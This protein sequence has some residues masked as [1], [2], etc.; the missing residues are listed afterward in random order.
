MLDDNASQNEPSAAIADQLV[1]HT[2]AMIAHQGLDKLS[3]RT[4]AARSGCS[5]AYIFQKFGN[6]EGLMLAALDRAI[7]IEEASHADLLEQLSPLPVGQTTL[8]DFLCYYV[9]TRATA[10]V[11]RFMLSWVTTTAP[12]HIASLLGTWHAMRRDFW[13]AASL[14]CGLQPDMPAILADYALMEESYA[15]A[16][17]GSLRYD[18]LLKETIRAL[19]GISPSANKR[20]EVSIA[21]TLNVVPPPLGPGTPDANGSIRDRLL[22]HAREE[23]LQ[24]GIGAVNQRSTARNAGASNSAIAYYFGSMDA[25]VDEAIWRAMLSDIPPELDPNRTIEGRRLSVQQ[26]LTALNRHLQGADDGEPAG[27]YCTYARLT[28]QTCLLARSRPSLKPLVVFLRE[29]DGWGTYR[30]S[31]ILEATFKPIGRDQASAFAIWIKG[32]AVINTAVNL[33]TRIS[34]SNLNS[35]ASWIFGNQ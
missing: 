23:I 19:L 35:G 20:E 3:L 7:A 2:I 10:D 22:F 29:L 31:R 34:V 13:K 8:G 21:D 11:P 16:L 28:V 14:Q 18:L 9:E 12:A 30:T 1:M 25:F 32:S 5:T 17:Q 15:T 4:I 6:S 27:F 24:N 26:W 33:K